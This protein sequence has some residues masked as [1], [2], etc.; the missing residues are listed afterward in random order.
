MDARRGRVLLV[1]DDDGI[2][3]A[4]PVILADHYDV[5][6]AASGKQALDFVACLPVDVVLLDIRMPELDGMEVLRRLRVQKP[7][8]PIILLTAVNCARTARLARQLGAQDYLVKP[9][10]DDDLLVVVEQLLGRATSSRQLP[11]SGRAVVIRH[12]GTDI[13]RRAA[14]AALLSTVHGLAVIGQGAAASPVAGPREIVVIDGKPDLDAIF[15]RIGEAQPGIAA[16]LPQLGAMSRR[17]THL[18]A[19]CYQSA[20]VDHLAEAVGC[21]VRHMTRTFGR[22]A[23]ITLREYLGRVRTEIGKAL[24]TE[25]TLSVE[26]IADAAG[27]YDA[28]HFAKVFHLYV[29]TSPGTYRRQ[30]RLSQPMSEIS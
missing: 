9:V 14:I 26:A 3:E 7:E 25:T 22:E 20:T 12:A 2:R 8:L 18:V 13:G 29:G 10:E 21:S 23:G 16:T 24:L 15:R 5:T 27:F 19:T 11:E 1:D 28:S 6:T 4:I 30:R 17:V